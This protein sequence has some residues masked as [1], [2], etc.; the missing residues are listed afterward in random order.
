MPELIRGGTSSAA[1]L[2]SSIAIPV[3]ETALSFADCGTP[4]EAAGPITGIGFQP[5]PRPLEI[6]SP[7][8]A[9]R[10]A[11]GRTESTIIERGQLSCAYL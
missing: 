10:Q 7:A 2:A 11:P 6:V 3:H 5:R 1:C 8:R 4:L 9:R